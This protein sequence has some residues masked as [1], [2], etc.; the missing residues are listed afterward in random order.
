M[1]IDLLFTL[2]VSILAILLGYDSNWK[3]FLGKWSEE[4]DMLDGLIVTVIFLVALF[5]YGIIKGYAKKKGF[6]R[7]ISLYWGIS[8]SIGLIAI[9]MAPIGKFALIV[10]PIEILT[11]VP[12]LGLKYF[13]TTSSNNDI[14]Y[15]VP[16]VSM[17]SSWSAG[18]IGYLLGFL[19]KKFTIERFG[20]NA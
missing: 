17:I 13:F 11:I 10:I 20:V 2:F 4:P 18:A 15:L 19:I 16:I 9:L 1:K 5:I 14:L 3:F 7:F 6:L 12:T 8:G